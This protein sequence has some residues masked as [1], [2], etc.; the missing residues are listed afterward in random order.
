M[1]DSITIPPTP[2]VTD[3]GVKTVKT[4]KTTG[5]TNSRS[6]WQR[7]ALSI[8]GIGV[9]AGM[10]RWAVFHLYALPEHSIGAFASLTANTEYTIS[11][12]VIFMV[13]GRLIYD[14][15]NNTASQIVEQTQHV[16]EKKETLQHV[17][18]EGTPGAPE[19]KPWTQHPDEP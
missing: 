12:I 3:G 13:T 4:V 16:F 8:V 18:E 9:L 10:W 11:A 15:K 2:P 1:D 17:I 5:P 14:W 7:L 19:V 6:P